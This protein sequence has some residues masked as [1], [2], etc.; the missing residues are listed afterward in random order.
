MKSYFLS[1]AFVIAA[2]S[3]LAAQ[4]PETDCPKLS[5]VGPPGIVLPGERA[6]YTAV[7]DTKGK[8]LDL[9]YKWSAVTQG[10]QPAAIVSGQ[11]TAAVEILL[12]SDLQSLTVSV[13][14]D[15][16]PTGCPNK[17][18]ELIIIDPPP[19]ALKL[20]EFNLPLFKVTQD[21]F[22]KAAA[23]IKE[24]PSAQLYEVISSK[25]NSAKTFISRGRELMRRLGRLPQHYPVTM[26]RG[27]GRIDKIVIW[28][29]PPGAEPPN[30]DK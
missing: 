27:A 2:C 13:E 23:A 16:F 12:S 6:G 11:G 17:A 26:I 18:T 25:N 9:R 7:V 3:V 21:R 4:T 19:Q 15:G 5:V 30:S 8:K 24:Q 22:A 14:V 29:V 1:A 28:L 10:G 20:D